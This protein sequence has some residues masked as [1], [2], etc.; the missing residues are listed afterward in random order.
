MTASVTGSFIANYP[1]THINRSNSVIKP[2]S[3]ILFTQ[4]P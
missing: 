1:K 4:Y 3:F 2:K